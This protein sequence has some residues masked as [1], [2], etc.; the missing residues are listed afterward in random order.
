M[1][2]KSI[3]NKK[4]HYWICSC[5]CERKT[6]ISI[7][8]DHL[9]SEKIM[10]CGCYKHEQLT[11]A[12]IENNYEK[13]DNYIIG[14]TSN[15][16]I[17]FYIDEE[18]YDKV[19]KR[20]WLEDKKGYIYTRM[21]NKIVKLHRYIME[22]TDSEIQIDH[23]DRNKKNNRKYNLRPCT[24]EQNACNK[25]TIKNN[26]SG[27]RGVFFKTDKNKWQVKI[28]QKFI[29]Y[30]DSYEEAVQVRLQAEKEYF[31]DFRPE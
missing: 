9:L 5:S 13:I 24:N 12:K 17:A 22:M 6:I 19:K 18:D 14:Y 26:K 2:K 30:C 16:N 21:N 4:H 23:K 28:R 1:K 3:N 20:C 25:D 27:F 15:T 7:R 11:K 31:G 8:Q 10:S 29:K